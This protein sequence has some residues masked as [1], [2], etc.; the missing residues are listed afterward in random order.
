M[1][2][3]P[4]GRLAGAVEIHY[5]SR[6][7]AVLHDLVA[8]RTVSGAQLRLYLE[9]ERLR[10]NNGIAQLLALQQLP[11]VP[12]PHQVQVATRVIGQ[13]R[14][15]A[16]LADEVGLG[17]TIE[18]GLILK[19]YLLR[20]LVRRALVLTPAA[21]VAQWRYELSSKF[22]L[23]VDKIASP[24]EWGRAR[25]VLASMEQAR[26][27]AHARAIQSVPWDLVI[28]DEAHRLRNP[29]TATWQLVAGLQTRYL[30]LLTAT[31]FQN[32]LRELYYLITLVKP[33][34]LKTYRQFKKEFVQDR[35]QVRNVE[36]LRGLLSEVIIRTTKD[37]ALLY[38]P[39]RIVE[40]CLANPTKAERRFYEALLST[41][42]QAFRRQPADKR[43]VLPL[44]V[45]LRVAASSASAAT[46]TL[47]ALAQRTLLFNAE[48]VQH[49]L[50]LAR[51]IHKPAKL[52]QCLAF[53]RTRQEPA[54]IFT[55]FRATQRELGRYLQNAG[56]TVALWHGGL[57]RTQRQEALAR[58][59][60]GVAHILVSTDVG[61]EGLNLQWCRNLVNY[62]LPWNPMRLEQR[63]GRI[64]RLGQKDDV[65]I[66]NLATAGTIE[67]YLLSLLE[68]K[69]GLFETVIGE[70][71]AILAQL[72][73]P[74]ERAF[75][76]AILSAK[77]GA[78]LR[79]RLEQ[80]GQEL[81]RARR[82]WESARQWQDM[83]LV[84]RAMPRPEQGDAGH[85][86]P[87][88]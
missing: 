26:R 19:E 55:E 20:G 24:N 28:V 41:C 83:V 31:P 77:D 81:E 86:A 48:E 29:E 59:R 82:T 70:V 3:L 5:D 72:E 25:L 43:N 10:L 17:K 39:R 42:Q 54:L 8:G 52:D 56:W 4:L 44:L 38:F 12:F 11:F 7:L 69:I 76:K 53:L 60:Q 74:F 80:L 63:I 78:D 21:L 88:I 23:Q 75:G 57:T 65:Y 79:L 67:E 13:M 32:D 87:A 71:D 9:G 35:H 61:G 50:D 84:D 34:Q 1:G 16:V 68:K 45:L 36:R 14:G 6:S 33:G 49:L 22:A 51:A 85:G 27:P 64:H 58:W 66:L 30:L 73:V 62:D 40:A 2:I 15:R 37:Q 18:A 47:I 46:M